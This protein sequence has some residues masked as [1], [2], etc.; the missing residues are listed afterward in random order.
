LETAAGETVK[1]HGHRRSVIASM[2]EEL[3]YE[4]S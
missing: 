2:K 1:R 3:Y 4:Y